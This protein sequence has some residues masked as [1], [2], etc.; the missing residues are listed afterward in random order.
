[1]AARLLPSNRNGTVRILQ[2][3]RGCHWFH[4]CLIEAIVDVTN[5]IPLGRSLELTVPT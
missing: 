5:G 3:N 4:T 1:M 2:Q